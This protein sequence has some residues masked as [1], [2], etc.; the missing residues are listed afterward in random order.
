MANWFAGMGQATAGMNAA[1]YGISVVGQN[2][3]NANSDGYT[4]QVVRQE[5]TGNRGI[6]GL[7]T[8]SSEDGIGGVKITGTFRQDDALLDGRVR[9]EHGK[10]SYASTTADQLSSMEALFPGASDS[11]FPAQLN[12]FWTDWSTVGTTPNNTAARQ[13]LLEH[14]GT[15]ASTL[16]NLASSVGDLA[17]SV[18]DYLQQDVSGADSAA[19]QLAALN[20]QIG[21]AGATGLDVNALADQ[22]DV[23][24][25]K[26]SK[27]TGAVGTV[28]SNGMA[29]VT[30]GG[31][32]L[33]SG[34]TS[35][36]I[37]VTAA[38]TV[39]VGGSDVTL[40]GGS[41]AA[42]LTALQVTVPAYQSKLDAVAN[43]LSNAVNS[44]QAAGYDLDGNAGQPLFA[45]SGAAGIHLAV[46]NGRLIAASGT[47]GGNLDGS[48]AQTVSRLGAL[49]TGP[50]ATYASLV[51]ALGA[52]SS[53]AQNAS[54]T[55]QSLAA[56][57]DGLK[58]SVS[59]VSYDEEVAN[60]LTYQRAF[61]ASSRALTTLDSML[62]TLI[63]HTGRAGLA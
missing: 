7:Y 11:G 2:I 62:D 51:G 20:A 25:D 28:Q 36:G 39:Q 44:A 23:L 13:V 14:A 8:R 26:L 37:A 17:A 16:N 56:N 9:D 3:A 46:T 31:A 53:A 18:G 21:A 50:D 5:S 43:T 35:V 49:S 45:G 59:G 1:R 19:S 42:R 6:V 33:V 22:R 12:D 60:M 27:L 58:S 41:A 30:V 52:E 48:N 32:T 29:T 24:L 40:T 15:L 57:L 54:S 4:K 61:E 10:A 63:N 47:P 34:A 38:G 55:Q